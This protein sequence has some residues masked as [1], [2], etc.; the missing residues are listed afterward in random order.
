M[1]DK[2]RHVVMKADG[3]I[4]WDPKKTLGDDF[5]QCLTSRGM[6]VTPWDV[7]M[8]PWAA[9]KLKINE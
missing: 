6:V 4:N 8:K 2:A 1:A 9:K 5:G 3:K 7:I